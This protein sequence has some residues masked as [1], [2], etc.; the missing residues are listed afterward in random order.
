MSL[1][2]HGA[3]CF[4][5]AVLAADHPVGAAVAGI[6]AALPSCGSAAGALPLWRHELLT[7]ANIRIRANSMARISLPL[8]LGR[9]RDLQ[10]RVAG[11]TLGLW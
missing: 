6:V 2:L 1:G 7:T 5:H 4:Q 10:F 9:S 11:P 8:R 3:D